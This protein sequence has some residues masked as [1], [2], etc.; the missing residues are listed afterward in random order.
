[1]SV[2]SKLKNAVGFEDDGITV[3][4]YHCSECD[5]TFESAKEGERAQCNECLS[6]DVE[7][8]GEV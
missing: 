4:E 3:Y 1:M 6:N 8:V 5:A 2:I 7:I